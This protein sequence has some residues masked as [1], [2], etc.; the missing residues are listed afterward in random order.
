MSGSFARLAVVIAA[1]MLVVGADALQ[2]AAPSERVSYTGYDNYCVSRMGEDLT[3][4]MGHHTTGGQAECEAL[5]DARNGCT[6]FEWYEAGWYDGH[7]CFLVVD[8]KPAQRGC[9]GA[10]WRDAKCFVRNTAK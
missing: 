10:L 2:P 8:P 1:S 4:D 3:Q 9:R 6:A 7:K 5:C